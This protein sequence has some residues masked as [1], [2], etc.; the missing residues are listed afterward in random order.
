[1]VHAAPRH[2]RGDAPD[3]ELRFKLLGA[4][5]LAYEPLWR[6]QPFC[7]PVLP[8]ETHYP[9][10][11]AALDAL[12]ETELVA[13]EADHEALVGWLAAYVP[14]LAG[15]LTLDS[16]PALPT[17][18][19]EY[20]AGFERDVPGRKWQQVSAFAA[21]LDSLDG[22]VL[23][24]CSGKAHL[25]RAICR[26]FGTP[27]TALEWRAELC[28]AGNGMSRKLKLDV[29]LEHCDVLSPDAARYTRRTR[30]AVALHACGDLHRRLLET[31]TA[32]GIHSLDLSPCCYH[33]SASAQY[34][35]FSRAAAASGLALSRDD[36]RLAVQETVTAPAATARRRV[37][38][39]AWRLGFDALQ[40]Q[41]RGVNDYLPVPPI[42]DSVFTGS[43]ADFCRHA[44]G[45]KAL[46]LPGA[47]DWPQL[48]Q[49]G[50]QRHARVSRMEL[51]R[52][53]FRRALELWL[54]LD[55]ALYL[56]ECGYYVSVG[57]FCER[58]LSPRNLM[59]RA[60]RPGGSGHRGHDTPGQCYG[61]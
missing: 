25:G 47:V 19:S 33:L 58:H 16:L 50:W 41:L 29:L 12:C 27:V 30:H 35:P 6:P 11:T 43:F 51:V 13:L 26:R 4:L 17:R 21:A 14:G 22:P 54:V 36:C 32:H 23:E 10:L 40:R 9:A 42:P 46:V 53:G 38:K 2:H 24:W 55:R 44:A 28:A 45:L 31:V 7:L 59:I 39:N 56:A 57:T 48:E 5:L 8:W 3:L 49:L 15:I 20:P 18:Y 60:N 52:H 1:V 37:Q 34:R 61:L